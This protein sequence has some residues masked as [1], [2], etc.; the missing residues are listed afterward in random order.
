MID[1]TRK[2]YR[3]LVGMLVLKSINKYGMIAFLAVEVFFLYGW[4]LQGISFRGEIAIHKNHFYPLS[5]SAFVTGAAIFQL[6]CALVVFIIL[7]VFVLLMVNEQYKKLFKLMESVISITVLLGWLFF[8]IVNIGDSNVALNKIGVWYLIPIFISMCVT[9]L[10]S[11]SIEKIKKAIIGENDLFSTVGTTVIYDGLSGKW[12]NYLFV[13]QI[14]RAIDYEVLY[15]ITDENAKVNI[16]TPH[17]VSEVPFIVIT[18]R[19]K[20]TFFELDL[21]SELPFKYKT[22]GVK[23]AKSNDIYGTS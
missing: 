16:N 1:H 8:Y 9:Q 19:V 21:C 10:T 11:V 5:D 12:S 13:Q 2:Q 6:F 18:V 4:M 20:N 15:P 14:R 22:R 17:I 7:L 23:G 3:K